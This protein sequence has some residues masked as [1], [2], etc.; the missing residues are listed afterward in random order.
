MKALTQN[1]Q[2]PQKHAIPL[3]FWGG[4]SKCQVEK[5]KKEKIR[6]NKEL[7]KTNVKNM[8]VL[9]STSTFFSIFVA[10]LCSPL[11]LMF[12]L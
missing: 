7:A 9:R 6:E 12:V 3:V 2:H 1:S 5:I 11:W 10:V 4:K 8:D